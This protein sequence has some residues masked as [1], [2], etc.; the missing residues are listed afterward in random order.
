MISAEEMAQHRALQESTMLTPAAIKRKAR[1]ADGGGGATL[2]L[3]TVATTVC[4]RYAE[5]ANTAEEVKGS[6][7]VPA[8]R[9]GFDFPALTD[10]REHDV[11]EVDGQ[12]F[13]VVAIEGPLTYETARTVYGVRASG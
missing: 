13:E 11:I 1:T 3:N 7:V 5:T 9:W 6:M 8:L 12:A 2:G 4:R 10:I